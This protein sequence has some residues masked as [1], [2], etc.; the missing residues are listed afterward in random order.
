VACRASNKA[1]SASNLETP[2]RSGSSHM[3]L[4]QLLKAAYTCL[5]VQCCCWFLL[6]HA[7]L[8]IVL[9]IPLQAPT[10]CTAPATKVYNSKFAQVVL[11][12]QGMQLMVHMYYVCGTNNAA[13]NTCC[14]CRRCS[15]LPGILNS[16]SFRQTIQTFYTLKH[17]WCCTY[18]RC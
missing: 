7:V 16:W 1:A 13:C 3:H 10:P 15:C 9:L 18:T 11:Y 4:S 12:I 8:T 17:A 6:T 5:H 2:Q 14:S